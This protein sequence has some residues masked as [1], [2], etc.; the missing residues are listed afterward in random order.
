ML[1]ALMPGTRYLINQT[2]S[3]LARE[4][5]CLFSKI[6]SSKPMIRTSKH[7]NYYF[8][9]SNIRTYPGRKPVWQR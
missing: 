8:L 5:Q 7:V 2:I 3:R 6:I 1:E 4:S 9:C